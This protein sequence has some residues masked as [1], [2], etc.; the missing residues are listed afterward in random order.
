VIA[1]IDSPLSNFNFI[2]QLKTLTSLTLG[3]CFDVSTEFFDALSFIKSLTYLSLNGLIQPPSH[4]PLDNS[5]FKCLLSLSSLKELELINY[6]IP[7]SNFFLL[8][9]IFSNKEI[10][11]LRFC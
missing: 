2:T 4:F 6:S 5:F 8:S 7:L 1:N 9:F 11:H 10:N 3:Y